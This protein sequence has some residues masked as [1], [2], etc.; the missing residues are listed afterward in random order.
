[1][2][3]LR[4]QG[5]S[6]AIRDLEAQGGTWLLMKDLAIGSLMPIRDLRVQRAGFL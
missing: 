2:R 6:S 5:A 3:D 4:V 1:M